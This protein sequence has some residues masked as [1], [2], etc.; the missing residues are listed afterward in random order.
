[1]MHELLV[2]EIIK[3]RRIEQG[4]TQEELCEGICDPVTISRIENIKQPPSRSTADALL[5]RLGVSDSRYSFAFYGGICDDDKEDLE[6][7]RQIQRLQESVSH[8]CETETELTADGREKLL[9]TLAEL[10]SLAGLG[11][12]HTCRRG[13]IKMEP[14]CTDSDHADQRAR[15]SKIPAGLLRRDFVSGNQ[16]RQKNEGTSVCHRELPEKRQRRVRLT[17]GT[18]GI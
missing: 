11:D 7:V 6:R 10:E 16:L 4:L 15:I 17:C 2:G 5:Q 14:E 9:K 13:G 1:M 18:T 3:K 8:F 12:Q